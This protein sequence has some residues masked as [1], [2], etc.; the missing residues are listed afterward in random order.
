MTNIKSVLSSF[1]GNKLT[2]YGGNLTYT[3]RYTPQPS[4]GASV[5]NSPDVVIISDAK[6]TLHHYRREGQPPSGLQTFVVPVH[7][8][9]WQHYADGT[10]A[11]RQ[12][13]LMALANV[14]AIYIKATYTT[15]AR[16]A[17]LS[18]VELDIA[19]PQNFGSQ[20]RAWEVE[21]CTCP[22]GHQGLSC[23]DCSPGFFKGEEGL[24]LGLCERCQCNGHSDECDSQTGVCINCRD[25]TEGENC[26]QCSPGFGG[27]ATYGAG[28][29][30]RGESQIQCSDCSNEGTA[31]CDLAR[32]T[33]NCKPN[34]DGIRCDQCR[35][36]TFGLSEINPYGCSECFCSG[37]T[38]SC[39]TGSYSR[40]EIP[41]DF[42][43]EEEIRRK[44]AITDREGRNSLPNNFEFTFESNEIKS[45]IDDDSH[46]Y[47][48]NLP[49]RLRGNMVLAYGGSIKLTQRTD[50]DGSYF[51]DQDV[52][53][54]GNSITLVYTREDLQ[55]ETYKIPLSENGWHTIQRS[56][57]KPATRADFLTV[58][59][60]VESILI[61]ASLRTY[62]TESIISDISLSSAVK[63]P[64]GDVDDIE[65]CRCPPGYKGTSCEQCE[66]LYYRDV[67]DR[68][69]GLLGAC[70]MCPCE[71]AASCSMGANRRVMCQCLP[72]WTGEFCRERAGE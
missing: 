46:V 34:V 6:I 35:E 37:T 5:S 68:S 32:R 57:P 44:F 66:N 63:N 13:L 58:L 70:K 10:S 26:E 56:G 40:D 61:R 17:S 7:E 28:G 33:C 42:Y 24:Y 64:D 36:G 50:G 4:G 69:V 20:Q 51:P 1:L 11:N 16:E 60:N 39:S 48:W 41:L 67:F 2:A 31:S 27:N 21:D 18:Q 47:Y 45:V 65:V 38:R 14:K 8:E 43:D 53:I 15:V 59:S 54:R 71:N 52:I 19:T 62:T 9:Y 55:E 49:D 29:C 72:G 3:V 12:H 25:N 30:V 23:E 22:L